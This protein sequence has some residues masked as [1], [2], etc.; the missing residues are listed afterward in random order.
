[1]INKLSA[2]RA[3]GLLLTSATV[4]LSV[5]Y[6]RS[7]VDKMNEEAITVNYA[8]CFASLILFVA[9]YGLLSFHWHRVCRSVDH[10]QNNQYMSFFASQPYKYLPTSLFS[11]SFRAN[12]ARKLG[13]GLKDN[14]AAQLQENVNL[15][16][17]GIF[18]GVLFHSVYLGY[19]W[20]L[21]LVLVVTIVV[22]GVTPTSFKVGYKKYSLHIQKLE[23]AKNMSIVGVAW[24]VSGLSF[25]LLSRGVGFDVNTWSAIAGNSFA[26]TLSIFAFF[27]PGGIGVREGLFALYGF[28]GGA[29]IS[30]RI[31]TLCADLVLGSVFVA[32]VARKRSSTK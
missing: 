11:F 30:W 5:L 16:S 24:T 31:L 8:L 2:F 1:M 22:Y 27:A 13:M 14:A 19:L 21:F 4:F 23:Q 15:L 3:L 32:I 17:M 25:Y 26:Y 7:L 20:P 6:F 28:M 12:Y 18:V 9:F 10:S 29:I